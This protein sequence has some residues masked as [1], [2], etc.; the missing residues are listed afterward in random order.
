[1]I[2]RLYIDN[3]RSL[4]NFEWKPGRL[5]LMLGD[6]G[7]GKSTLIDA[8]WGV[9]SIVA[10]QHP[11]K[12]FFPARSRT[13]WDKRM[14]LTI[15]MDADVSGGSYRYRLVIEHSSDD[16]KSRISSETLHRDEQPLMAF[17]GGDLQLYRD[18]GTKGPL[19]TGD[20][21]RSA[22]GAIAPGRD[23]RHLTAF[24]EW[25]YYEVWFVRPDPRAMN[26]RT[27]ADDD[28]G[29]AVNMADFSSWLRREMSQDLEG[30]IAA[31]TTLRQIIEGFQSLQ[32]SR[33]TPRLEASF[34]T[35]ATTIFSVDFEELSD[36]QRQLCA[37]Y[38]LRHLVMKPRRLVILDEPDNYLALREIQPWLAE[39]V[40]LA[41]STDGPQLWLISH[42][43]ELINQLAPSHGT[44]F[45]RGLGPTRIEP[46]T[47]AAGL[48]AAETVAR[49]WEGE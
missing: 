9:R 43:P 32:V 10:E 23:N 19:V 34:K 39:A 20:W 26:A 7:S 48:T 49:G 33:S 37:L 29:L 11:I 36:G 38:F 22:L 41:L 5:A 35:S 27:D 1:V 25:L 2:T 46:F 21:T 17:A 4:V 40:D 24:K 18:G 15:E 45:F 6:N 44:R 47:G 16:V 42:H 8:L 14:D 28:E 30:T 3:F 13:R 31:T 12:D